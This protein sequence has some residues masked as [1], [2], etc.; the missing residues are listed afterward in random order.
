MAGSPS[1]ISRAF[2]KALRESRKARSLT[3]EDFSVSSGRTYISSLERGLKSPTLDKIAILAETLKM[4]PLTLLTLTFLH[5]Q[6][7]ETLERLLSKIQKEIKDVKK[8][9]RV[10]DLSGHASP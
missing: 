7:G 9:S 2:A 1:P 6:H 4:H 10:S 5:L 3:Q 8:K